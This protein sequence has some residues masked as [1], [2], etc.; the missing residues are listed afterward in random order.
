VRAAYARELVKKKVANLQ[1]IKGEDQLADLLTKPL[2]NKL[3]E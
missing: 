3:H 1:Y 2:P